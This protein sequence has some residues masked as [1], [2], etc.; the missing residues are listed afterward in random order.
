MRVPLRL[1]LYGMLLVIVFLV[2]AYAASIVVPES[3]VAN[4]TDSA[5]DAPH[6]H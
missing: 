1:G 2:S 4:W 6:G 5:K 3:T